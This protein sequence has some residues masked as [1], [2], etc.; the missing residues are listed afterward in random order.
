MSRV[1]N[2][3]PS[4][5]DHR[6]F[7]FKHTSEGMRLAP[8]PAAV[9]LEPASSPVFDQGDMGSCSGCSSKG[10]VEHLE[11]EEIRLNLPDGQDPQEYVAGQFLPVSALFIYWNERAMEGTTASDNGATT[12]RDACKVLVAQ[13]AAREALW[14]YANANL[15]RQPTSQAFADAAAHKVTAFYALNSLLDMKQCLAAG[16][17]F[18]F[19]VSV[20]DSFMTSSDG[21][22]PMPGLFESVQG[23]HALLCVGYDDTTQKFKFKNSWGVSFGIRGYGF[24]P[25]RY[26][27][28]PDLSMDHYTLRRIPKT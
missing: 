28:S 9:D 20:Y 23:G 8:L 16:Y 26:M 1:L 6:D 19:G 4:L 27:L 21:N 14:P 25:Y 24:L 17:P 13:G 22:I 10:A 18:L 3:H 2:L 5:P 12:L 7:L 11:L 15:L